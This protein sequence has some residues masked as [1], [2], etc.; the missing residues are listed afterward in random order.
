[1]ESSETSFRISFRVVHPTLRSD[2]ISMHLGLTPKQCW[3]VGGRAKNK[4][5]EEFGPI[6]MST[7]CSYAVNDE[8]EEGGPAEQIDRFLDRVDGRVLKELASSGGKLS[9]YLAWF[10]S[11]RMTGD[12]FSPDLM[13]RMVDLN[14]TLSV[15]IYPDMKVP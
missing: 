9:F 10:V 11:T 3:N 7:Y 12:V 8:T 13:R 6:K 14:A 1:M 15:E 4:R 5:N 2:E